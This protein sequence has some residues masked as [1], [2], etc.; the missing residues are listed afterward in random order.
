MREPSR[1]S[2]SHPGRGDDREPPHQRLYVHLAWTTL[3]RLRLI[4]ERRGA[5]V[6]GQLIVLCRRL[7]VRV[8]A[9]TVTDDRVHLLARYQASQCLREVAEQLKDGSEGFLSAS[10]APVRWSRGYAVAS[11]SP[12][13]VRELRRRLLTGHPPSPGDPSLAA[14]PT[15]AR[16]PHPRLRPHPSS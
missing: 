7:G 11:V 10:G 5:A 3:Q 16:T 1:E 15:V 8:V 9:V 2:R 13:E 12:A 6:E 4:D 14:S